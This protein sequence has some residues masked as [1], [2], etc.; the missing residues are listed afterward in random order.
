IASE[1]DSGQT[2]TYSVFQGNGLNFFSV[3][4]ITGEIFTVSDFQTSL[5][6]TIV[7]H[8]EVTDNAVLF[9]SDSAE[10]T[11]HIKGTDIAPPEITAFTIPEVALNLT[12]PV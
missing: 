10:I 6:Q 5:D 3:D 2:V 1:P 12:I 11:I 7:L 8:V 4:S 9:L